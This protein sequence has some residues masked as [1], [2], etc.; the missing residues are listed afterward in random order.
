MKRCA[1]FDHESRRKTCVQ[2]RRAGGKRPNIQTARIFFIL[3]P[4]ESWPVIPRGIKFRAG[5][6]ECPMHSSCIFYA[7]EIHSTACRVS[8]LEQLLAQ[9]INIIRW[10]QR[11]V[12]SCSG[13][14]CGRLTIPWIHR[15]STTSVLIITSFFFLFLRCTG[16]FA[17][18]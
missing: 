10:Y 5:C 13:K 17:S 2:F 3:M 15:T 1:R 9:E 6:M 7:P 4:I 18:P 16:Q 12:I 8:E 14:Q 11:S